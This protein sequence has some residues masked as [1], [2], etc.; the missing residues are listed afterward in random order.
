M[1]EYLAVALKLGSQKSNQLL[2]ERFSY[3]GGGAG[4]TWT[5]Q[6]SWQHVHDT[7]TTHNCFNSA[8]GITLRNCPTLA[9]IL[10]QAIISLFWRELHQ[11][12][13]LLWINRNRGDGGKRKWHQSKNILILLNPQFS[14]FCHPLQNLLGIFPFWL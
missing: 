3:K 10:S 13:Q 7:E 12:L 6:E 1:L 9:N 11:I 4:T 8:K 2:P 14:T 5:H